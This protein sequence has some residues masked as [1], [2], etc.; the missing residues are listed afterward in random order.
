MSPVTGRLAA[1]LGVAPLMSTI[2]TWLSLSPP[3]Q[4]Q[5]SQPSG[6]WDAE[7]DQDAAAVEPRHQTRLPTARA[8]PTAAFECDAPDPGGHLRGYNHIGPL[9]VNGSN[10]RLIFGGR[11][12]RL[13]N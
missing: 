11:R 3:H 1:T 6:F 7:C 13:A 5:P 8:E 4:P 12:E 9:Q 2:N 10:H